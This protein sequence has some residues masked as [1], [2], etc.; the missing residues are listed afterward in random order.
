M[1]VRK[2][3]FTT[4]S[5]LVLS[6]ALLVTCSCGGEATSS[7]SSLPAIVTRGAAYTS[8][9]VLVQLVTG[10][11]ITK[12]A[13]DNG[14][15]I[16]ESDAD[17]DWYRL[18]VPTDQKVDQFV[19]KLSK[20]SRV[21]AVET[22][23]P[24]TIPEAGGGSVDGNPIHLAF[25]RTITLSVNYLSILS[26]DA[27]NENAYQQV[28]LADTLSITKGAG[29]TIAVLDTGIMASHPNLV[30]NLVP[31]YNVLN[32]NVLPDDIADGTA[33]AAWGH[34]TMVAGVIARLAPQAKIMPI[35][36][37]DADGKG[38]VLAVAKGIKYAV[39]HGARV[40]NL[41]L[42]GIRQN[43]ALAQAIKKA[44]KAG[45]IVVAAAGN[46]GTNIPQYPAGLPN[47]IGVAAADAND[48]K[49]PFSTYGSDVSLVA[50]G[51]GIR[52]TYIN[53]G[54]ATWSG[55]S[56]AAPFV[57]AAAALTLSAQPSLSGSAV[58][59]RLLSTGRTLDVQNPTYVGQLGHG[60]LDIGKAVQ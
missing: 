18:Q 28:H 54:Y 13:Q 60:M 55:S 58:T 52:S 23:Q 31:G 19:K 9:S 39:A 8:D 27:I 22:D 33:N 51:V 12:I 56:F 15:T 50:P 35:R 4:G 10:Q 42:G 25:D 30:N 2:C 49:A 40:L 17:D 38:S 36:V 46:D 48:Q 44:N 11:D 5:A 32:T 14:T 47:V 16:L 1:S 53:G 7:A 29:V 21:A 57:S 34:G 24:V 20:D 3:Y 59:Q 45:V 37:L 43:G 41:S 6:F 26:G